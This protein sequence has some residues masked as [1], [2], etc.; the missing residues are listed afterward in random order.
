MREILSIR[1]YLFERK[2]SGKEDHL[3][4]W[5][6]MVAT[7]RLTGHSKGFFSIYTL[8]PNQA[9]SRESQIKINARLKQLPE[10]KDTKEIII[11]KTRSL[12]RRMTKQD[13]QNLHD[14]YLTSQFF[15]CEANRT[16][17]IGD[18]SVDLVV[19]SPPFLDVVQYMKDNWLRVWFN[20]IDSDMVSKKMS[21]IKSVSQWR[22]KMESV[23]H[24]LF[25][26]CK[27][28]AWIAFEVGEVRKN[29]VRLDEMI[30]PAGIAAGFNCKYILVNRQNFTKTA[31]IWGVNNNMTGTNTNR[32]VVF[33]KSGTRLPDVAE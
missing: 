21:V 27:Q 30:A 8:P 2:E 7:N 10:Y 13:I 28:G 1:N 29:T 4:S 11:R 19:T 23:F 14:S 22:E 5:I 24:E 17:E 26:V 18:E 20:K 3:D 25:R 15:C 31:N 12:L 6:R 16:I 9:V 33:Q 32:I